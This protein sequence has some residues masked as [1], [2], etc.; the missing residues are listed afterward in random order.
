MFQKAWRVQRP[1]GQEEVGGLRSRTEATVGMRGEEEGH[2]RARG[3]RR[4]GGH[5]APD[6]VEAAGGALVGR[7]H[8]E[9]QVLFE[10]LPLNP[11]SEQG[12]RVLGSPSFER[13]RE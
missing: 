2:R 6:A 1:T 3:R 12:L 8:S 9:H 5:P 4:A 7:L 10:E 13:R 11:L